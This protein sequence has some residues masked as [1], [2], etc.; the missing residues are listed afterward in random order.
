MKQVKRKKRRFGWVIALVLFLGIAAFVDVMAL[1]ASVV[2][3]MRATVYLED[4]PEAFEGKTILYASD[5]DLG[6]INTPKR[7]AELFNRL[8]VLN[9]DILLLGGDY[10]AP[11]VRDLLNQS[12]VAQYRANRS[13][14]REDFFQYISGFSA[15][16]GRY[17]IASPDDRR[18]GD[19]LPLAAKTGFILLEDNAMQIDLDG[20]H[21]ALV[22]LGGDVEG[23]GSLSRRFKSDECVIAIAY[24]PTQLP[25]LMTYEASDSGHWVDLALSGHTHGGQIRVFNRGI[26]SMD[27]MEQRFPYGW[28]RETGVPML[29][30]SGVGC[31]GVNLRLNSRAEVWLITLTGAP[32]N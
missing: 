18:A 17:M 11:T 5:I 16:L 12:D 6:G 15:P 31:E 20:D 32:A 10:T 4:L 9:P 24:S 27:G 2:H 13:N 25:S 3:L 1:N 22:G 19:L 8:Q 26:L 7:A 28:N 23:I 14:F 29:V 30:T 21:I